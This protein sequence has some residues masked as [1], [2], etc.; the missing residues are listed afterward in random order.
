M[1]NYSTELRYIIEN[2]FD[3]GMDKYPVI[4]EEYRSSLNQKIYD[5]YW[6]HEIGFETVQRF[7]HY[8]NATM[9]E[10]MPY[11][12]QLLQSELLEINPFLSFERKMDS[13]K[14]SD[15]TINEDL[16]STSTKAADTTTSQIINN[17][18]GLENVTTGVTDE[19][20]AMTSEATQ[21]STLNSSKAV[22]G[23]NSSSDQDVFYDTPNGSLADITDSSYATTVNKKNGSNIVDEDEV[24]NSTEGI[25]KGETQTDKTDSV[26]TNTTNT[27]SNSDTSND[28]VVDND[29]TMTTE[30]DNVKTA[31][32]T[33]VAVV[34][35]NGFQIPLSE[36]LLKYRQ[37]FLNVDRQIIDEL[38]DL[39][40]M[41]Y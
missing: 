6:F 39:F 19:T 12:N 13:S 27:S 25:T 8:L 11:Y 35:E 30:A 7:K 22:D 14:S 36:L 5:H 40:M 32:A 16:S 24:I 2:G 29:E 37:T 9:N 23:N 15:E 21:D 1:S 28:T 34:T 38:K 17:T 41:I 18:T 10:I 33:E 4:T 3:L 31:A 20:K 26:T